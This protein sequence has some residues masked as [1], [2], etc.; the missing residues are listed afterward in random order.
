MV[1]SLKKALRPVLERLGMLTPYDPPNYREVIFAALT[2]LHPHLR[3]QRVLEIGPKDGKDSRRLAGLGP[4]S[5][6]M[7]DIPAEYTQNVISTRVTPREQLPSW[8]QEIELADKSYIEGNILYLPREKLAELG[9]FDLIWCT[10]VLY[11]NPE[12]LRFLKR[13]FH[14]LA[15]GGTLILETSLT[16]HPLLRHLNCVEILWPKSQRCL[17]VG[18]DDNLLI[19]SRVVPDTRMSLSIQSNVSHLP[20]RMAVLS[21][22]E[23]VGFTDIDEIPIP[24]PEYAR[25][26]LSARKGETKGYT[27]SNRGPHP[28]P[29]C[30]GD[31]L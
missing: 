6:V 16:R 17:R 8:F 12:P 28:S 13:L 29:Y 27:Y 23:M 2:R 9:V 30:I 22:L 26:A 10:G 24:I 14:L 19:P 4:K 31:S 5:L 15:P 21:W 7:M 25:F 20:S 11:H 18:E 1:R 3:G